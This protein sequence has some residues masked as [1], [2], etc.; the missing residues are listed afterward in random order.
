MHFGRQLCSYIILSYFYS[1]LH[2]P[3]III[4]RPIPKTAKSYIYAVNNSLRSKK[5]LDLLLQLLG[6]RDS[7]RCVHFTNPDDVDNDI[8]E[9]YKDELLENAPVNSEFVC[10]HKTPGDPLTHV[11]VDYV[12]N[13]LPDF[14]VIAPRAK[15]ELSSITEYI[16]NHVMCNVI[17]CKN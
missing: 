11:I 5:G 8:E 6:P 13:E 17:L 15:K 2:I 3:G 4:K 7:L 1:T 16:M 14:F 9:Y 10:I 12:N